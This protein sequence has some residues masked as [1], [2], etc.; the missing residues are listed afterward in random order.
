MDSLLGYLPMLYYLAVMAVCCYL[1]YEVTE[2]EKISK[3]KKTI[4]WILLAVLA[5]SL[6]PVGA[7]IGSLTVDGELISST[8]Y[9]GPAGDLLITNSDVTMGD[10]ARGSESFRLQSLDLNTGK[11]VGRIPLFAPETVIATSDTKIWFMMKMTA[12]P[13]ARPTP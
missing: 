8:F 5:I 4:F 11:V 12:F 13:H 2:K 6:Y 9:H 1:Y 3:V 7:Y 10:D